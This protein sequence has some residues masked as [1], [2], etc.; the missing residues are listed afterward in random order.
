MPYFVHPSLFGALLRF[1]AI[2]PRESPPFFT[3][4]LQLALR[5]RPVRAT[6]SRGDRHGVGADRREHRAVKRIRLMREVDIEQMPPG[7]PPARRSH[8]ISTPIGVDG[9][10]TERLECSVI[11]AH[12][13]VPL[14]DMEAS[15]G[16]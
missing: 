6:D 4:N 16:N 9:V 15:V 13:R 3:I 1:K 11:D 10:V 8:A 5:L 14:L 7:Y 12:W 2:A